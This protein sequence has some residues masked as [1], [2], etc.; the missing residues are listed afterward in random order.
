MYIALSMCLFFRYKPA[1]KL[2]LFLCSYKI[3]IFSLKLKLFIQHFV[4]AA[5]IGTAF[6]K[7]FT[8]QKIFKRSLR[9]SDGFSETSSV[10]HCDD[11]ERMDQRPPTL[12]PGQERGPSETEKTEEQEE[13]AQATTKDTEDIP[14]D[15]SPNNCTKVEEQESQR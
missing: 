12:S 7:H 15:K 1:P 11:L 2:N 14:S 4:F 8:G 5:F 3:Q 6:F 10:S 9:S 13:V